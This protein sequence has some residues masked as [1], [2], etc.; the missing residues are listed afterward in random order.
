MTAV[1]ELHH[2]HHLNAAKLHHSERSASEGNLKGKVQRLSD[3]SAGKTCRHF[4]CLSCCLTLVFFFCAAAHIALFCT[5]MPLA[6]L[7]CLRVCE[8]RGPLLSSGC[9]NPRAQPAVSEKKPPLGRSYLDR[10]KN[11]CPAV[12]IRQP[13][14]CET[15]SLRPLPPRRSPPAAISLHLAALPRVSPLR[16]LSPSHLDFLFFG[17]GRDL[18]GLLSQGFLALELD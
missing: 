9:H 12:Y 18:A 1:R 17:G 6:Q 11:P 2:S 3:T 10:L 5:H 4:D 13:A 16:S 14:A 7:L 15:I 8:C